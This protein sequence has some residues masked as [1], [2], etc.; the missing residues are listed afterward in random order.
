MKEFFESPEAQDYAERLQLIDQY[1]DALARVFAGLDIGD[2]ALAFWEVEDR[3]R[4]ELGLSD[5]E[6]FEAVMRSVLIHGQ[7][8]TSMHELE[9]LRVMSHGEV[10]NQSMAEYLRRV[11]GE[12]AS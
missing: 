5:P 10:F 7:E 11:L 12:R 6:K 3:I 2:Q 9:Q 4:D 1:Y 8:Y